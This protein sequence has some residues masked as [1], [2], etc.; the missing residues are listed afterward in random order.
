MAEDTAAGL[1]DAHFTKMLERKLGGAR[2]SATTKRIV[3]AQAH[4]AID[5]RLSSTVKNGHVQLHVRVPLDLKNQVIE[6]R[7]ARRASGAPQCDVSDIVAEALRA[8]LKKS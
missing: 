6:L 5:G 1:S 8:F 3:E 7:A 2:G 4:Q